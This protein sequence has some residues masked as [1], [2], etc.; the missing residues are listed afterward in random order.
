MPAR[1]RD[2]RDQSKDIA[3]AGDGSNASLFARIKL[4]IGVL[5]L[6][7]LVIFLLQNLQEVDVHFLWFDWSTRMLWAL[8]ASA[9]IGALAAMLIG[10][11]T[12]RGSDHKR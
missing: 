3:A 9:I 2:A 10:T 4:A 6:A 11:I 7:A 1:D 12:R 5:A 8:M